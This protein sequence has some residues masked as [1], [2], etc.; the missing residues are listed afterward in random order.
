MRT[1]KRKSLNMIVDILHQ[2]I[3]I[4]A[5]QKDKLKQYTCTICPTQISSALAYTR[6]M[7]SVHCVD[8]PFECTICGGLFKL[9]H[10]LTEHIR[11]HTC[12]RPF[13]CAVC[14]SRFSNSGNF[15]YHMNTVHRDRERKHHSVAQ[16]LY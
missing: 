13:G 2:R 7:N 12:D 16:H 9:Q 11:L 6:H 3:R 14:G 8:R 15:S 1:Q 4:A 10:H 5:L